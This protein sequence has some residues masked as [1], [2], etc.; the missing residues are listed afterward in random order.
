M[1]KDYT[2]KFTGIWVSTKITNL[3]L[4]YMTKILLY[5]IYIIILKVI[6]KKQLLIK[7]F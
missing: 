2:K 7:S 4:K 1:N 3:K 6:H 5:F